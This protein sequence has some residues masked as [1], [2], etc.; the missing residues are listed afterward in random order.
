MEQFN[1]KEVVAKSQEEFIGFTDKFLTVERLIKLAEEQNTSLNLKDATRL[2]EG[3]KA[4]LVVKGRAILE[5]IIQKTLI[6][7]EKE[8]VKK[9]LYENISIGNEEGWDKTFVPTFLYV[10]VILK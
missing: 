5:D 10:L 6:D 9:V 3:V 8:N 2:V 4:V 1:L 7:I